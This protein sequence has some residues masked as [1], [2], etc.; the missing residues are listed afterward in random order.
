MRIAGCTGKLFRIPAGVHTGDLN[1]FIRGV[2]IKIPRF[3]LV[4]T[5][6]SVVA[7]IIAA[8]AIYLITNFSTLEFSHA[9]IMGGI[10]IVALI[11]VAIIL[12]ILMR[13][14]MKK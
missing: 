7:I 5:L 6:M 8:M 3:K 10:G 2:I 4:I 9:V 14:I 13:A 12:A 1:R 11:I